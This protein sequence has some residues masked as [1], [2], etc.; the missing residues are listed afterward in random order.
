MTYSY[1]YYFRDDRPSWW[2]RFAVVFCSSRA[3]CGVSCSCGFCVRWGLASSWRRQRCCFGYKMLVMDVWVRMS[4][5]RAPRSSLSYVSFF[6]LLC[7]LLHVPD[8]PSVH[9]LHRCPAN[10]FVSDDR[11]VEGMQTDRAIERSM[12]SSC[13]WKVAC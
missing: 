8:A 9:V 7:G 11:W 10:E 12:V 5:Y 13:L 6:S 3:T 2:V 1:P 4:T